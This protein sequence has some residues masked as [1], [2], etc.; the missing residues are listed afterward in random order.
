MKEVYWFIYIFPMNKVYRAPTIAKYT[1][2]MVMASD[3]WLEA[4]QWNAFIL[5]LLN[6][7]YKINRSYTFINSHSCEVR[8]LLKK[9][10]KL[11]NFRAQSD[12]AVYL[13]WL[14]YPQVWRRSDKYMN[15]LLTSEQGLFCL[16]CTTQGLNLMSGGIWQVMEFS[17]DS[18]HQAWWRFWQNHYLLYA[19]NVRST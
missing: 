14:R 10:D 6:C 13:T 7:P 16:F 18:V 5:N 19:N 4:I 1:R 9:V 11:H 15:I 2:P 17:Q 12:F 8:M 3:M